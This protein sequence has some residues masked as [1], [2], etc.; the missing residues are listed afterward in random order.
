MLLYSSCLKND[1]RLFQ[2]DVA[3]RRRTAHE[4]IPFTALHSHLPLASFTYQVK[5]VVVAALPLA[6][7]CVQS[8]AVGLV[9]HARLKKRIKSE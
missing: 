6:N 3:R 8:T 1:A 2:S 5:V 7:C 9:C 4:I